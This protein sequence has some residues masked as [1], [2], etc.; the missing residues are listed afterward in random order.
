M[1]DRSDALVVR[2]RPESGPPRRVVF[3][4]LS[5]GEWSRT[6]S[7]WRGAA[8]GGWRETGSERVTVVEIEAGDAALVE[9]AQ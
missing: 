1:T 8:C 3:E 2:Y 5:D 7:E 6:E 9:V 4:P